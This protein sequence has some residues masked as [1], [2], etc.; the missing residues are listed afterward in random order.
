M[1]GG[2]GGG[3]TAVALTPY[4]VYLSTLTEI[5]KVTGGGGVGR[6]VP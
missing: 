3:D 4:A 1:T 5:S 2:G 6:E